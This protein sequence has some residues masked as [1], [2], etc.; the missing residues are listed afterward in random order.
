M[1]RWFVVSEETPFAPGK[2]V[3][4]PQRSSAAA[5]RTPT[6]KPPKKVNKRFRKKLLQGAVD[7]NLDL[8]ADRPLGTTL[9]EK[10][11]QRR[12][13]RHWLFGSTM[14]VLAL[15]GAS[16]GLTMR[17]PTAVA[18]ENRDA[19]FLRALSVVELP[20]DSG[21]QEAVVPSLEGAA[22]V[23]SAFPL[24]IRKVVVDPGHGGRDGGTS[25]SFGLMEKDLTLD[26][27][28]RP[29]ARLESAGFVP[30]LTRSED[31]EISLDE[32]TAA[33]NEARADLFVSIHVN[34]LPDRSARGVETYY[35]GPSDDPF[36]NRLAASENRSSG[37]TLADT[38]RLLEVIYA[39]V[40]R[41]E[42]RLLARS[43][44]DSLFDVLK[45]ENPAI[46]SRGVMSAPFAVLVTTEMPAI[47]AEVACISNDREAR[48]LAIP[49]YRQKIADA[50]AEGIYRFS[51]HKQR[52]SLEQ[53]E[54]G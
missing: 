50:L 35:L 9:K 15:V 51:V 12:R 38:R 3:G 47:L 20:A 30:I 2:L 41:G 17:T 25:L 43:V 44:Q 36:L 27:G 34:W 8:L 54:Q 53:G 26:I 11:R 1:L 16:V 42:S 31:V 23:A 13:L 4:P 29:A 10:E 37:H 45:T 33:A 24:S 32:R 7:E 18:E 49:A 52:T 6:H 48:L 40:R 19:E 21:A 5:R 39:D 14:V 28:L 46:V 22:R